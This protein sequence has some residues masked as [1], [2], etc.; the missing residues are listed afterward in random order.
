MYQNPN[1]IPNSTKATDVGT[2]ISKELFHSLTQSYQSI[3]P[4]TVSS[5]TFSKSL[6]LKVLDIPGEVAGIRFMFGLT[7]A[8][9]PNSL[10]VLMVPCTNGSNHPDSSKPLIYPFGYYDQEGKLHSLKETTQLLTN[11]VANAIRHN[12]DVPYKEATRGGFF[13]RNTLLTLT[14]DEKCEHVKFYFGWL[15]KV[16]K[17][18]LQPLDHSFSSFSDIYFD[19]AA[20]CPRNCSD[21]NG[22]CL[23]TAA[24]LLS[25]DEEEL[26]LYRQ[27]RDEVLLN[28]KGGGR[29]FEMYYFISPLISTVISQKENQEEVLQKLY[30]EKIAPFKKLILEKNYDQAVSWLQVAFDE[31]ASEYQ[32]DFDE[33]NF[34]H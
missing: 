23:A 6:V 30:V 3:F 12:P 16:I 7:D 14:K 19:F 21:E 28:L 34:V 2:L 4:Q 29:H 13:G 11:F 9:N 22:L 25:G 31:L 10:K 24:V 33:K 8:L 32:V 5:C 17:P 26:N 20:P 15:D 18:V 27:F 1:E